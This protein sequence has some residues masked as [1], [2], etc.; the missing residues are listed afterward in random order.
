MGRIYASNG[1]ML[2]QSLLVC[3]QRT[4]RD[5]GEK[6][7]LELVPEHPAAIKDIERCF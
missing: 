2:T 7:D 3:N 4:A 5:D 1:L 6:F